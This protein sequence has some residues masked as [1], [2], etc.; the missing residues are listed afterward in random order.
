MKVDRR[1]VAAAL[2]PGAAFAVLVAALLGAVALTLDDAERSAL[3]AMLEPRVALLALALLLAAFALGALGRRAWLHLVA[4]PARL[5]EAA[6][7]VAEGDAERPLEPQGGAGAR[8]LALAFDRVVRDRAALRD[9]MAQR[10]RDASRDIEQERSRLAALMSELTQAV[11]VCN[12]DGRILLYN[13]RARLQCLALSEAPSPA[14]GAELIGIGRSIYAVLDRHLVAHALESV[15]QR[16]QRGVPSPTAQFVTHS[17]G[18]QLLRVQMAPVRAI[19]A[20]GTPAEGAGDS[21]RRAAT[22]SAASC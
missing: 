6:Q 7:V 4:A 8:A 10:V 13:Q 18:G 15:Q 21:R 16:L 19:G 17:R 5:A 11:V 20:E 1:E 12:L 3:A 22:R 2:L 14:G 9:E